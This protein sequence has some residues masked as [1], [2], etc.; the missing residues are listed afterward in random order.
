[1][2]DSET[3]VLRSIELEC[4]E[5]WS[6]FAGPREF[7]GLNVL[8]VG[9]G[10]GALCIDMGYRG[11][12]RVVGIDIRKDDI[13]F[14]RNYVD[15]HHPELS[16]KLEFTCEPVAHLPEEHFDAV[17]SKDSFEHI[18]DVDGMLAA[19][20]DRLKSQGR[21]Y[22]GFSPLYH[23]PYGDHDRRRTAFKFLGVLGR[24]LAVIPWGHLW[25]EPQILRQHA[26]LRG[27]PVTS[28]YQLNLNQ[29]SIEAFRSK[30]ERAGLVTEW[31]AVNQGENLLGKVLSL[32]RRIPALERYCTYNVYCILRRQ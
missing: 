25:M 4:P 32:L 18:I 21:I 30:I 28:M 1:M 13:E 29:M 26:R 17:V 9:C 8:E 12:R 20:R 10:L 2:S 19:I 24:G 5:F 11:A 27:E 31:M 23:S 3:R 14:A 16:G 6:R 15:Q 22:I 7:S